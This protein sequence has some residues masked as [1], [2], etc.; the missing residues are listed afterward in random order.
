MKNTAE[1]RRAEFVARERKVFAALRYE[2]AVR[3]LVPMI[4]E[5]EADNAAFAAYL[6]RRARELG[7]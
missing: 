3:G 4:R 2:M 1:T 5:V 7:A 6:A